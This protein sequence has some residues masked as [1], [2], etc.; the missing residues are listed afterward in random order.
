MF[1]TPTISEG[2][3]VDCYVEP[4]TTIYTKQNT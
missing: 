4:L 2:E 1:T 3:N